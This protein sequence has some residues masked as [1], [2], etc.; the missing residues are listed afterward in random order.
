M[1]ERIIDDEIGRGIRL[2]KTKNGFVDAE[3]A[4]VEEGEASEEMTE[5]E[6]EIAFEFPVIEEEE[7]DEDLV[8]LSPEEAIALRKQKAE[9][10]A[11]RIA[12][13]EATCAEGNELLASGSFHAAELKFEKALLLDK[14]AREASVGYWRAKT[15]D[16]TDPDVLIAEYAD[17]GIDNLENDLGFGAVD[18]IKE[19]YRDVFEKR[20]KELEEEET[21]LKESFEEKRA[22]RQ[23]YL[24]GR[25]YKR[26]I[27]FIAS[28]LPF[29]ALVVLT[30]IFGLRNITT[31]E[32]YIMETVVFAGLSVISFII[33]GVFTNKFINSIRMIRVN[34]KLSSTE[35]GLKI[36]QLRKYKK[37]Y[38][39]LLA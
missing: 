8:S 7:D 20:I 36:L 35:E 10:L 27:G 33:F 31:R 5:E 28:L 4:L 32:N 12:E 6:M 29:A 25:F 21:P 37:L 39:A 23:D 26:M 34:N 22:S 1:E 16:F 3:D 17:T 19:K 11:K 24:R 18:I 14:E 9:A 13:Y 15:A 2:K 38:E 30:A